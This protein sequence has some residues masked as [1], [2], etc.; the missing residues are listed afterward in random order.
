MSAITELQK[1][2]QPFN[3]AKPGV[4]AVE[5]TQHYKPENVFA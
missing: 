1:V 4:K 3:K 2:V 5:N